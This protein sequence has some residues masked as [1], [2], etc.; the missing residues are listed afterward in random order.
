MKRK[1]LAL[2]LTLLMIFSFSNMNVMALPVS[3][4]V[5]QM[6]FEEYVLFLSQM[7]E[8][9]AFSANI[10]T[11]DNLITAS[12]ILAMVNELS[13]DERIEFMNRLH[14]PTT[15]EIS[16]SNEQAS[17]QPYGSDMVE[18]FSI[19]PLNWPVGTL[20]SVDRYSDYNMN[21]LGIPVVRIRQHLIY[22]FFWGVRIDRVVRY[23][24]HV[25]HNFSPLSQFGSPQSSAVATAYQVF[26]S[27]SMSYHMGPLYEISIQTST[28]NG[29][30]NGDIFGIF[31]VKWWRS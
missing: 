3:A 2:L 24:P 8:T 4:E 12:D 26:A 28:F 13:A 9:E 30:M 22:T 16:I 18:G 14:D 7:V 6:T 10:F 19:Q 20:L 25:L 17:I 15:W 1:I 21:V 27:F 31:D 29:Y 23:S 11:E 5:E